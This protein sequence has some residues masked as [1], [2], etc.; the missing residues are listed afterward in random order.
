MTLEHNF[1]F[2]L[3]TATREA[4]NMPARFNTTEA[5]EIWVSLLIK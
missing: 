2:F 3:L 5:K 4:P 1:G